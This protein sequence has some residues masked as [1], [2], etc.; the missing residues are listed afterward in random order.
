MKKFICAILTS[1]LLLTSMVPAFAAS[2]EVPETTISEIMKAFNDYMPE[3][4]NQRI[5]IWKVFKAYML[6]GNNGIDTII[7]A[8]EG[9]NELPANDDMQKVFNKFVDDV[10][11]SYA[12]EFIFFLQLYRGTTVSK[13]RVSLNNFGSDNKDYSEEIVKTPLELTAEEATAA[14]NLFAG[15][16]TEEG[17]D[18]LD[19]HDI[20]IANFLNLLTPFNGRFQMTEDK[21]G[22]FVLADF[23]SNYAELLGSNMDY[24]EVNGVEINGS[25]DEENGYD[26]LCGVAEMFND[27][28]DEQKEDFKVVLANKEINLYDE[29]AEEAQDPADKKDDD[30]ENEDDDS[31][32]SSSSSGSGTRRPSTSKD[33]NKDFELKAPEYDTTAPVPS[34]VEADSWSVPYV[35][36]MTGRKIFIGYEDGTFRPDIGITRQEIAVAMIRALGREADAMM[37]AEAHTGFADN[38]VI[39]DWSRG[40]VNMAVSLGLFKGYEDGEFKPN[41]TISRQEL[42]TV[43]MRVLEEKVTASAS[44]NYTDAD[45]I[46]GYAKDY[47]GMATNL[48]IVGGYPDGTFKPLNDI[49]RAEAAK[50]LYNALAYYSYYFAK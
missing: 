15:Y 17:Q 23:S 48:S 2:V 36:N 30:E 19:V 27:F 24:E 46:H 22:D 37:A 4:P 35:M 44:M 29:D 21:N 16:M 45:E 11:G 3:D 13:R 47:V 7:G 31:T 12:D 41:R 26:I 32:S 50:M 14:A 6:D 8:L 20:D 49:T 42:T 28:S 10:K 9:E 1:A 40:Y 33:K 43:I 38:D 5:R 25:T 39:A 34:D 18:K